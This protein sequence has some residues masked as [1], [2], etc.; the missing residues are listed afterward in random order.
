[1]STTNVALLL[2]LQGP[3]PLVVNDAL[4]AYAAGGQSLA[5]PLRGGA[6]RIIIAASAG[7]SLILPSLASEDEGG[8]IVFVVNDGANAVSVYCAAGGTLN[9]SSNGSL[10]IA[11]GGFGIFLKVMPTLDWRAAAFT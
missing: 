10:S 5:T 8:G 4:T 6:N 2:A 3:W 1:M 11:S 7:A 9:G